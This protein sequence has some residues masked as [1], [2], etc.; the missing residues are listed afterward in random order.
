MIEVRPFI[1][2]TYPRL[3][4]DIAGEHGVA[5]TDCLAGT[6]LREEELADPSATIR[7]SQYEP[8]ARNIL[9]L[10]ENPGLCYE[11]GMRFRPTAHGFLGYA[12]MCC[13]TLGEALDLTV[14]FFPLRV[15]EAL[16]LRVDREGPQVVVTL[17]EQGEVGDL[18]Q[19][20]FE[21]L[22]IG[23]YLDSVHLVGEAPQRREVEIWLSHDEPSYY[24]H[25]KDRLPIELVYGK[26]R[27][28]IRFPGDYL[29]RPLL[30]ANPSA[31]QQAVLFCE[32]ELEDYR[33]R[34]EADWVR[35]VRRAMVKQEGG[36]YSL[37]EV[38]AVLHLSV[39][40]LKRRLK[41]HG[42]NYHRILKEARLE[43]AVAL[44]K[45]GETVQTVAFQ[46]GYQDP[47]NFTRAF[48]RWTGCS[49]SD[50]RQQWL[51]SMG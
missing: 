22:L 47:A 45:E 32:R 6:G 48:R 16:S 31:A 9:R 10:T 41:E 39:R 46:L 19:F 38:A 14:R 44:L 15:G 12:A 4:V 17:R 11:F 2:M 43:R 24:H 25:Y 40:T 3:L 21:S 7:P 49:P 23:L 29:D 36:Y 26:T 42:A 20:L 28:Q 51:S 1:P 37:E 13:S 5:L 27:D 8:L 33:Q 30:M 35:Q 50:Y 18:R 34:E